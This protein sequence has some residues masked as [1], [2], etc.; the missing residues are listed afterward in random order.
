MKRFWM[1]LAAIAMG[2]GSSAAHPRLRA[3]LSTPPSARDAIAALGAHADVEAT[4]VSC[5]SVADGD[6]TLGGIE[7]H[8]LGQLA[9]A[10]ASE[11]PAT[12]IAGCEGAQAPWS[13]VVGVRIAIDDPWDYRITF[14]LDASGA[15][16]PA[17]IRCP[18]T[19]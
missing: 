2:C 17:S 11:D 13:C 16:D 19:G 14:N 12:L 7:A 9:E 5:A 4:D 15:I 3:P 18:G 1:L 8:L 10:N 6:I